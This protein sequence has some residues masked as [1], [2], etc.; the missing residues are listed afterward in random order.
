[1]D[2][3]GHPVDGVLEGQVQLGLDV[4][5]PL[6]RGGRPAPAVTTAEQP[7]EQV[8]EV[9]HVLDPVAGPTRAA[10]PTGNPPVAPTG[11][12]ARTSSYS[13]RLAASPSTS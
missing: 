7:A 5:S 8:A 3:G 4:C 9:A 6:G 1:M 11:P 2:S 10:E 12:M 13:L